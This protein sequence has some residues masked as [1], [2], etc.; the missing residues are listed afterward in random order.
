MK[1]EKIEIWEKKTSDDGNLHSFLY[2]VTPADETKEDFY[3]VN[4]YNVKTGLIC[5]IDWWTYQQCV[6]FRDEVLSGRMILDDD[7]WE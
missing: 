4:I 3:R 5:R 1:D 2:K 7:E 6:G